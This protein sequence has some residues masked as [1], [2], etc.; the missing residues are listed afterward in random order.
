MRNIEVHKISIRAFRTDQGDPTCSLGPTRDQTCQ[1][2]RTRMFGSIEECAALG[3]DIHR[4]P[5]P[6]GYLNPPAECPVWAD[7]RK[8][9]TK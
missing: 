8:D 1:F 3:V 4:D 9:V 6:Y 5:A 7:Y 2:F